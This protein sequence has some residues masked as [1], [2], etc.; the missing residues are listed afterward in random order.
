MLS[1]SIIGIGQTPVGE[2]WDKSLRMLATDAAIRAITDADINQIDAIY[3]GNAY[4][5][6]V[7]RQSHIGT[8]IADY[9]GLNGIETFTV[10]A[11]DASGAAALRTGYMAVASGLAETVLVTGVEKL[12]D[13]VSGSN[14]AARNTSLDADYEAAHGATL[15]A[16]AGLLMRRYMY[17]HMLNLSAFEGFSINAHHNGSKNPDAMFRNSLRE[18]SFVKAPM[19][20]DPVNLFDSAPDGDGAAAVILTTTERAGD[21]VPQP[22]KISAS[23]VATDTFTLQDRKDPLWFS[24]VEKSVEK[25]LNH[26]QLTQNDID[27]FELSDLFT[28]TTVLSLEAAGFAE[29]GSGWKMAE[30]NGS[31]I[32]LNGKLPISTFGGLKAR[33]NPAGATGIYQAVEAVL[34]LRHLAQP[35]QVGN[36]RVAMIQNLGGLASTAITHILQIE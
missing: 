18:G 26:A 24:A 33:G 5:S 35:N 34:Q 36:A 3:V 6:T 29:R 23:A 21:M 1:V 9:L 14:I 32:A 15:P 10:E 11:A 22:I 12:T 2:H 17:E 28:I 31:A 30:H 7:S 20:S 8:M 13:S 27:F 25:A 4:G 16:M 19:I